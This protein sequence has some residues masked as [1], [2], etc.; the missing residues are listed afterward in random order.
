MVSS[1][2]SRWMANQV[3][4]IAAGSMMSSVAAAST[5]VS[6]SGEGLGERSRESLRAASRYHCSWVVTSMCLCVILFALVITFRSKERIKKPER[7]VTARS[8]SRGRTASKPRKIPTWSTTQDGRRKKKRSGSRKSRESARKWRC[9]VLV[10]CAAVLAATNTREAYGHLSL[11]QRQDAVKHCASGDECDRDEMGY[12]TS[13]AAT[14]DDIRWPQRIRNAD[15]GTMHRGPNVRNITSAMSVTC[16][17]EAMTIRHWCCR[18]P[19]P[20]PSARTTFGVTRNGQLPV[21][22]RDAQRVNAIARGNGGSYTRQRGPETIWAHGLDGSAPHPRAAGGNPTDADGWW[23]RCTL[24]PTQPERA[25]VG[26]LGFGHHPGSRSEAM[27]GSNRAS[28]GRGSYTQQGGWTLYEEDAL[29]GSARYYD[30]GARGAEAGGRWCRCT[31]APM[32]P[33]RAAVG[34]SGIGHCPECPGD[35][36]KIFRK[37]RGH[38]V[39]GISNLGWRMIVRSRGLEA[40][41][42]H[43]SCSGDE[44]YTTSHGDCPEEIGEHASDRHDGLSKVHRPNRGSDSESA[45]HSDS[46]GKIATSNNRARVRVSDVV[47]FRNACAY[48]LMFTIRALGNGNRSGDTTDGFATLVGSDVVATGVGHKAARGGRRCIGYNKGR[49]WEL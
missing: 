35:A 36:W 45:V 22:Q 4:T 46:E 39:G 19:A 32:Q 16:N 10:T 17:G 20:M 8:Q 21:C 14:G 1:V 38:V 27:P 18:T 33:E 37:I 31:H 9:L 30:G 41:V 5:S 11:D 2:G 49:L 15:R 34:A 12:R 13:D 26:A 40:P 43:G 3:M 47:T 24:A 28:E 42:N 7:S 23:C 29:Q 25:A 6:T 44:G 48:G